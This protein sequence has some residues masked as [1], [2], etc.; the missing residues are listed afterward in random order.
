MYKGRGFKKYIIILRQSFTS[1]TILR[2]YIYM[3]VHVYTK[4]EKYNSEVVYEN[5]W[6]LF[7]SELQVVLYLKVVIIG[8]R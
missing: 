3:Y 4:H 8:Q 2:I 5:T 1:T 7:I 6:S